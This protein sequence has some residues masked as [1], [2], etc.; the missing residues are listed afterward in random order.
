LEDPLP[1]DLIIGLGSAGV[2]V[3][4]IVV[5]F[6]LRN[7]TDE[8]TNQCKKLLD[9]IGRIFGRGGDKKPRSDKT[10]EQALGIATIALAARTAGPRQPYMYPPSGPVEPRF[11]YPPNAPPR[12]L[13]ASANR[14]IPR[15]TDPQIAPPK[16]SANQVPK[17]GI[18]KMNNNIIRTENNGSMSSV[19]NVIRPQIG[20]S[21]EAKQ[22]QY[23]QQIKKIT[24]EK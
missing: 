23:Q 11:S 3:L 13:N 19:G 22:M 2:F 1:L 12:A 14:A 15:I 8:N 20:G 6:I 7:L 16:A 18:T 9:V 4:G 21:G 17:N 10:S 5:V 24:Y